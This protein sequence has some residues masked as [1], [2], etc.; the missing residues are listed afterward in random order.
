MFGQ[1][2]ETVYKGMVNV[3]SMLACMWHSEEYVNG[4]CNKMVLCFPWTQ[5]SWI[6]YLWH[7]VMGAEMNDWIICLE[8]IYWKPLN[9]ELQIGRA[10]T[11]SLHTTR[12][13]LQQR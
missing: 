12:R 13:R 10:V 2:L 7:F 3:F 5:I 9:W 6:G 11:T 1:Q 4:R 8:F